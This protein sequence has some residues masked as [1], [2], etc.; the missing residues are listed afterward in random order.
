MHGEIVEK[1]RKHMVDVLMMGILREQVLTR[2]RFVNVIVDCK[3][4]KK[5]I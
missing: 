2:V 3:K 4:N 5:Y 1:R